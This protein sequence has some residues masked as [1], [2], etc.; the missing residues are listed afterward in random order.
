[1]PRYSQQV[2]WITLIILGLVF[3]LAALFDVNIW[4]VSWPSLLILVG[5]WYLFRP[6]QFIN[7]KPI[8]VFNKS[9][10]NTI[11]LISKL[12]WKLTS[13]CLI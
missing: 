2:I 1:M 8:L 12:T 5:L 10:L 3:L 4:L 9:A 13:L 11:R 6:N 7:G